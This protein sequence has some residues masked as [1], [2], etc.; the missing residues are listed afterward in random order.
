[1]VGALAHGVRVV[2][3]QVVPQD[4]AP[5]MRVDLVAIRAAVPGAG[6]KMAG[7]LKSTQIGRRAGRIAL[8]QLHVAEDD[9]ANI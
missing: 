4:K 2:G 3:E 6:T 8:R 5:R 9:A 7:N 1:M